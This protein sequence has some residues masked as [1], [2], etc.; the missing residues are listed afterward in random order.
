VNRGFGIYLPGRRTANFLPPLGFLAG[1]S[2]VRRSAFLAVS[3]FE[4][5][6][7]FGGEEAMVVAELAAAG[8]ALAYVNEVVI[9]HYP[10]LH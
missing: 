4:P 3:G 7:F 10:S 9:Y 8:W 6:F 5:R 2:V 1:A